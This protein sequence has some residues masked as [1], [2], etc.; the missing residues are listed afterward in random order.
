[1]AILFAIMGSSVWALLTEPILLSLAV[2]WLT[3]KLAGILADMAHLPSHAKRWFTTISAL[4]AAI[5][6]LYDTVVELRTLG[7]Y[8]ETFVL[9][10]LLM[11][12]ALQ[13]TRRQHAGA[14]SRELT[15]RWTG[16]GFIVGLGFW[17]NPL[18]I[19]AVIA[20]GI[21]ILWNYA[22]TGKRV[23]GKKI[24]FIAEQPTQ[25]IVAIAGY[26]SGGQVT[27]TGM[28]T[29]RSATTMKGQPQIYRSAGLLSGTGLKAGARLPLDTQPTAILPALP[30]W[31]ARSNLALLLPLP[32]ALIGCILGLT[33]ALLWG[34]AH[35]WQNFTYLFQ[36]SG[37]PHLR[38]EVQAQYPTRLSLFFGLTQLY[39]TCVGPRLVG[40]GLPGESD[41][42]A[43]LH[44]PTL[45]LGA[46]CILITVLL[47]TLSLPWRG[48]YRFRKHL[49]MLV[50]I[51]R[52]AALP[53]IFAVCSATL[54]CA[55][56][57]A[58][59]GLWS[60]QYD[61]AGRYASPLMLV[62]PFFFA[63][64]V[65]AIILFESR[66]QETVAG[67][68]KNSIGGWKGHQSPSIISRLIRRLFSAIAAIL[69]TQAILGILVALLL[70]SL[71]MQVFSYGLTDS[72]STFQS[73][74]CTAVP[75]NNDAIIAYLQQ[76]QIHYAWANN[77]IGYS[78]VFKTHG[79]IIVADPLPLI[80]QIPIL[81]RIPA[82]TNAVMQADRASIIT[83][84]KQ[85]DRYPLIEMIL[86]I[87]NVT[88][89][90]ARF[91]SVQD[92]DVLVV[93]PLSRTVSPL[94]TGDFYDVFQCSRNV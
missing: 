38:P 5:P 20:A 11:I 6:P 27:R 94:E 42:L 56:T 34:A 36:L 7:G 28:A 24:G 64:I 25:S 8:I 29:Q 15:W 39:A 51:R 71:Y 44:T 32:A 40:G 60:C 57:T 18:I 61:L 41:L 16:I 83:V 13:L 84:V 22:W 14:S 33:P 68:F 4:L 53:L 55:T 81:N 78:I 52:L 35:Q 2:V 1:M 67:K 50:S 79:N 46:G 58:A 47:V 49:P 70:F 77:W 21:W 72:E 59:I 82:N 30:P 54:F 48:H 92:T 80:R 86:D 12:S 89:H 26:L 66:V 19:S 88:Y 23:K 91:H 45:I 75:A 74:Y 65:V 37:I 85:N 63:S 43:F 9:M 73:P 87:K 10:L 90:V 69:R 62:L 31:R 93:T 3:W 17:V 76:E